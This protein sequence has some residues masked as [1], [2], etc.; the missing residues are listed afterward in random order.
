MSQDCSL[1]SCEKPLWSAYDVAMLDLD[2][3]VYIGPDAVEGAAEHLAAAAEAGMSLAYVTN[4]AS[5]PPAAVAA[6]LV[7]LG[8]PARADDVVTSAQAAARLVADKVPRGGAVFVIGGE[9]LFEALEEVGLTPVQRIEDEPVAVVSGY[10]P[11]L[12]WKTVID[13]AILV[14]AGVPW[15]ASNTD[16][17]V[18][19]R[20]G[21]G[22]GNGVLV[23]VVA[24][25]AG[26]D[27]VVAGKPEPPLFH[28]T[29]LRVGGERPLVVGDRLDTDIEGAVR[30]GYDSLLVMTGV[31]GLAELVAAEPGVRPTY[32]AT[33]LAGLGLTHVAPAEADGGWV[34]A[35]WRAT[36]KE[37]TLRVEGE[38]TPDDWLAVVAAAAWSHL[39]THGEPVGIDGLELPAG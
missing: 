27:P 31:T 26:V 17:S 11:D 12:R 36:T 19:T 13:G 34:R 38:G 28:E 16:L 39:D 5:R 25:F 20:H 3:V 33:T 29:R 24:E 9:G 23:G 15:F 22:P 10:H 21:P 7:E 14:R 18:P 4:N 37:G 2:G 35:G 1:G 30:A 32:L 8:M 6:H